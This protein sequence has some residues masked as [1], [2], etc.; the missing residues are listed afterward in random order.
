[1]C[2][3]TRACERTPVCFPHRFRYAAKRLQWCNRQSSGGLRQCIGPPHLIKE[4]RMSKSLKALIA[5]GLV[6]IV[7]ACSSG[8]QEEIIIVEPA[9]LEAEPVSGKF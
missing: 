3:T 7:A 6:A 4:S 2:A 1:M 9:P 5:V 8:T